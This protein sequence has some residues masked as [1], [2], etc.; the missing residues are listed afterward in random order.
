MKGRPIWAASAWGGFVCMLM[1][2]STFVHGAIA[3]SL[4]MLFGAA[5]LSG[6][7]VWLAHRHD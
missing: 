2:F 7:A 4:P 6:W 1:A 5:I 3:A